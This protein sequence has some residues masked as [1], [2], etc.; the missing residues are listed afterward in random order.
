M[1]TKY[2]AARSNGLSNIKVLPPPQPANNFM[3][4]RGPGNV[5]HFFFFLFLFLPFSIYNA[6]LPCSLYYMILSYICE[7]ASYSYT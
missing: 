1:Y 7:Q 6:P 5:L 3:F 2:P 4:E